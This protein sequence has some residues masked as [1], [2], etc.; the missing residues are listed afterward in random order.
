MINVPRSSVINLD[1]TS[2]YLDAKSNYTY[3]QVGAKRVPA[4]TSGNEKTRISVYFAASA[5]GYKLKPLIIVPRVNP[6]KDFE[7]PNNVVV[8][9]N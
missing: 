7:P 4:T 9:Y 8:V 3:D 2:I 1:E 5:S 6:L